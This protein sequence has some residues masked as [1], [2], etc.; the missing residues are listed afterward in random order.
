MTKA[1]TLRLR[2]QLRRKKEQWKIAT[3]IVR[4]VKAMAKTYGVPVIL[5]DKTPDCFGYL[6]HKGVVKG[7]TIYI[8][9]KVTFN[10]KTLED[11][12]PEDTAI[13]ALHEYAHLL[14]V[15]RNMQELTNS[16]A[17]AI[18]NDME[19]GEKYYP[20]PKRKLALK[21]VLAY[22]TD[23]ELFALEYLRRS[24]FKTNWPRAYRRANGSLLHGIL[25]LR[26]GL[27]L[28]SYQRRQ[29]IKELALPKHTLYEDN[30]E[31]RSRLD[32]IIRR[33]R[34]KLLPKSLGYWKSPTEHVKVAKH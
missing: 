21:H 10:G 26:Y 13:T 23:A 34:E 25:L 19:N 30:L 18:Y 11:M 33:D 7:A 22:E 8:S 1:K 5:T 24:S 17:G 29:I 14:Q 4:Q 6:H 2:A 3:K 12:G 15:V 20:A 28:N 27:Q 9:T 31:L 16:P 32:E